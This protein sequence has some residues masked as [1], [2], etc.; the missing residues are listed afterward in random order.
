MSSIEI[1]NIFEIVT[2]DKEEASEWQTRSDLMVMLR[3]IISNN[4]WSQKESAQYLGLSQSEIDDLE[5][6][7]IEKLPTKVLNESNI[8]KNINT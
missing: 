1:N 4:G 2:E 3:E 7:K 8:Q 5:K 6:G